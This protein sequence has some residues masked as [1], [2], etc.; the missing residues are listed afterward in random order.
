[1]SARSLRLAG[2]TRL[3]DLRTDTRAM[4]AG[5][6]GTGGMISAGRRAS[7]RLVA[8]VLAG[9][10]A[11]GLTACAD[12]A[13]PEQGTSLEDL[14]PNGA[15]AAPEDADEGDVAEAPN[16]DTERFLPDQASYLG[17]RV[18]VSGRIVQVFDPHAF[19]IG[20]GGLATLVTRQE[21]DLVLQP[22][23]VAQVTGVVGTF[24]VVDV[25][26]QLAIDLDDEDFT[27][28]D[29]VPHIAAEN[30]NLLDRES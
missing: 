28:F 15:P 6:G 3:M 8:S 4:D 13:G 2:Q 25:E 17:Q 27:E 23:T 19:V 5:Q 26:K 14:Q 10:L 16:D 21:T 18:T 22:G 29:G 1:V 7:R 20:E 9:V 11:V 12:S 30:V 24:V